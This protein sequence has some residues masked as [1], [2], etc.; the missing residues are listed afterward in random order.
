MSSHIALYAVIAPA[1]ALSATVGT[2]LRVVT[3]ES[4]VVSSDA[5]LSEPPQAA[6]RRTSVSATPRLMTRSHRRSTPTG[7][8]SRRRERGEHGGVRS[9]RA[10]QDEVPV[11]DDDG[12]N[13]RR[14]QR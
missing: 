7:P 2:V 10:D 11:T 4:G 3:R 6:R 9:Q 13:T 5:E 1:R 14:E 12:N 8:T